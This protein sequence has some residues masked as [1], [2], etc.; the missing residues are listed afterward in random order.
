MSLT[1]TPPLSADRT[2]RCGWQRTDGNSLVERLLGYPR[3][4]AVLEDLACWLVVGGMEYGL[5]LGRVVDNNFVA[6]VP[7]SSV[8]ARL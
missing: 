4:L 2:G 8:I 1:L 7:L 3:C 6:T 5:S